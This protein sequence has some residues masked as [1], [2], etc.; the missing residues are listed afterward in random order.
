MD[1][2]SALL[3][4]RQ[5]LDWLGFVIVLGIGALAIGFALWEDHEHRPSV[6]NLIDG[7]SPEVDHETCTREG[8]GVVLCY[9]RTPKRCAG[10]EEPGCDHPGTFVCEDHRIGDTRWETCEGCLDDLRADSGS[11]WGR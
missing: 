4:V 1:P 2:M 5:D 8:C 10:T 9:C 6:A 3:V 7:D 11:R